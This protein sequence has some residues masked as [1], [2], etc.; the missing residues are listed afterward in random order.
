MYFK[1]GDE[2]IAKVLIDNGANVNLPNK[3]QDYPLHIASKIGKLK[4]Q[5]NSI[6]RLVH[7]FNV[8]RSRGADWFAA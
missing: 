4:V 5:F 7:H 3:D 6:K 8:I 2:K 1:K